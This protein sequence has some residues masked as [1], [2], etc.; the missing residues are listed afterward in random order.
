MPLTLKTGLHA[1][2]GLLLLAAAALASPASAQTKT[3]DLTYSGASFGD[4]A[5]ATGFVTID[6][7]Q[8]QNPGQTYQVSTP[9]VTDFSLT[10]S[11]ASS[12][13]GTF[14][15]ADYADDGTNGFG[16]FYLDT[17]GGTLELQPAVESARRR[18]AAPT[19]RRQA[20]E[21]RFPLTPAANS[22]SL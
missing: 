1:G 3:F 16:G 22:T 20:L 8:I 11:G 10:V 2:T 21:R 4:S 19:G 14:K 18:P 7:S 17:N 15:F 5:V 12:G 6:E 13:N 9:F